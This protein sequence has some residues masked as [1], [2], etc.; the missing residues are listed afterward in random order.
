MLQSLKS[1][2]KI[3]S[4]HR[5]S[6]L[7]K[8][9]VL[10]AEGECF[11]ARGV[12]VRTG[13]VEVVQIVDPPSERVTE[14]DERNSVRR[15]LAEALRKVTLQGY[16]ALGLL[17]CPWGYTQAV[18]VT[19]C[20]RPSFVAADK[21]VAGPSAAVVEPFAAGPS[22]VVP[23]FVGVPIVA[24]AVPFAAEPLAVDTRWPAVAAAA[25]AAAD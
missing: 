6:I 19:C 18:A 20:A 4:T 15:P 24:V 14:E 2:K 17:P 1:L 13:L 9:P 3:S 5:L 8:T 25:V 22:A 23:S 7:L 11:A 12:A 21:L 10:D 16:M